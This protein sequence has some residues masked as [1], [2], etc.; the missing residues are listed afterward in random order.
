MRLTIRLCGVE[1]LD[2]ELSDSTDTE[3]PDR[4]HLH[5]E[6]TLMANS[7]LVMRFIGKDVNLANQCDIIADCL[8]EISASLHKCAAGLRDAQISDAA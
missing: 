2:L 3:P 6:G 1:L 8:A 7:D 5:R 4:Q